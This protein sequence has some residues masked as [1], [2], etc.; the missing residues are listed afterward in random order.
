MQLAHAEDDDVRAAYNSA[1]WL[2]Q[3]RS[4]MQWWAD[5]HDKLAGQGIL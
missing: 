4:M 5:H 3:R 1:Q 2:A